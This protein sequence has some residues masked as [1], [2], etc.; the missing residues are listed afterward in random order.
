[1]LRNTAFNFV[2]MRLDK[3]CH[4]SQGAGRRSGCSRSRGTS[5]ART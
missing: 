3:P 5:P 2:E 4:S 1:L